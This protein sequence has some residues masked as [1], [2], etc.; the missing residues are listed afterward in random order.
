MVNKVFAGLVIAFWA[1]MM[2]ALVR[3]DVFPSPTTLETV[4]TE[5]VLNKIFSNPEP[6]RLGVYYNNSRIGICRIDLQPVDLNDDRPEEMPPGAKAD[7]YK[8]TSDLK[9]RL[10]TFGMPARLWLRGES[11]LNN[12]LGLE[13]FEFKTSIGDGGAGDGHISVIGDD[14]AGKVQVVLDYAGMHDE[15]TYGFNQVAG[16][17]FV[18]TFGLPGMASFGVLGGELPGSAA[19]SSSDEARPPPVTT[20]Y[21]DRLEVAGNSERVYLIYSKVDDQMWTKLWVDDSGQ[22]LKLATSLGLEMRSDIALG[23]DSQMN[24]AGH[25]THWWNQ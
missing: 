23:T 25:K 17:G 20:T 24:P 8:V 10:L 11:S 19:G 14:R 7:G 1:A 6:V 9:V 22:I 16:A 13:H 3:L 21:I 18:G 12:K 5:R 4:S 15:R 2:T